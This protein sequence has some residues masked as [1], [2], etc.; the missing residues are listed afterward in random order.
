VA[1]YQGKLSGPLLDR[2]D[3]QVE[4]PRCRPTSCWPRPRRTQRER[5]ARVRAARE[6]PWRARACPTQALD[7]R[8]IDT[9][10]ACWTMR[11]A[12]PAHRRHAPGLERR[13]PRTAR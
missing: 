1:R 8:R 6:R 5:G 11:R 2:I 13:A 12:L 7:G 9:A 10:R 3:L 4:V